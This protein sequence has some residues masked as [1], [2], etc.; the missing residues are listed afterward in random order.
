M[1]NILL[2]GADGQMGRVISQILDQSEDF[3]IQA[4][5]SK[6]PSQML[7][8][9]YTDLNKV[10]EDIDIVIDFSDPSALGNLLEYGLENKIGLVLA[11]TGYTQDQYKD[12]VK[13]SETIPILYSRNM[14]LGVNVMEAITEKMAAMLEDFDI[15]IV[16]RHHKLKKDS[17]SGTAKMLFDAANKGRNNSMEEL[18][19]RHGFYD[20][21]PANEIGISAVRGGNIVGEHTVI[22]AGEDELL[23][24][25]HRASSK[26][27]FANGSLQAAKFL[28]KAKPGLYDMKDVL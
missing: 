4:G 8:P 22:F 5:F 28:S 24:L 2:S 20:H 15:E 27:I 18:D 10:G 3:K 21:R 17:P 9:M 1:I 23:E 19:G 11:S 26:K 14:S 7:Y 12:I 13:A 25:T 16:E 6:N